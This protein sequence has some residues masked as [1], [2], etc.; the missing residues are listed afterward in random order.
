MKGVDRLLE[1]PLLTI[2]PLVRCI[3]LRIGQDLLLQAFNKVLSLS[4]SAATKKGEYLNWPSMLLSTTGFMRTIST[5][6][7]EFFFEIKLSFHVKE[8]I[9][10]HYLADFRYFNILLLCL[11][12]DT[13]P[14]CF[15][16]KDINIFV[17]QWICHS[18][19][20]RFNASFSFNRK[21]NVIEIDITQSANGKGTQK[22]VGPLIVCIQV[23]CVKTILILFSGTFDEQRILLKFCKNELFGFKPYAFLLTCS[24]T[25]FFF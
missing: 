13:N 20:A 4:C 21:R 5:V 11:F 12:N 9:L 18:G 24:V 16:G 15:L 8:G 19:V 10:I 23:I 22:Y 6:S 17:D 14:Y 2:R 1:F 25:M 3:E 7:G